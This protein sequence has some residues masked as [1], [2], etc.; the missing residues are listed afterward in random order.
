M[1][2]T[3]QFEIVH[4]LSND[5]WQAFIDQHPDANIFQTPEMFEVFKKTLNY[6]PY[7]T[8]AVDNNKVIGLIP[9][10]LV[11]LYPRLPSVLSSRSI[12]YGG[13]LIDPEKKDVLPE[14]LHHYAKFVQ[15]KS[16]FTEFRNLSDPE[17]YEKY[18]IQ[19]GYVYEDH[20]NYLVDT[21][22]S[23]EILWKNMSNQACRNIKKSQKANIQIFEMQTMDQ[24]QLLYGFLEHTFK[25]VKVPIPD[26]SLFEAIYD[27]LNPKGLSKFMLVKYEDKIIAGG[28]FL[29]DKRSV[30]SWYYS[31]DDNYRN[32][33]PTDA[34]IWHM[35]QW[36]HENGYN[37]FD[38]QWAGRPHET[39]GVRRFK[40]K[41]KGKEVLYGRHIKIHH[42]VIYQMSKTVYGLKRLLKR[43][44][45]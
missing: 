38:F 34:M 11:T 8:A 19:S 45:R 7:L 10:V 17:L 23:P 33:F 1:K 29:C 12:C 44:N 5:Q 42:P 32:I 30:Y 26:I 31:A 28:L 22:Q 24:M 3:E 6:T 25:A 20:I 2:K 27:I 37:I 21:T 4:E 14:L 15:S 41:Y 18:L 13:I 9:A 43:G 16:L 40:E 39:Y 36:C 35:L